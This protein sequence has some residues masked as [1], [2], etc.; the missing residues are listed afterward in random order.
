LLESTDNGSQSARA[1]FD[2]VKA[3][4]SSLTLAEK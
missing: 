2:H 4:V 1:E 3:F